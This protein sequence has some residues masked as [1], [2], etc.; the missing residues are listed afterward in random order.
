M[1]TL[2]FR[3]IQITSHKKLNNFYSEVFDPKNPKNKLLNNF[4]LEVSKTSLFYNNAFETFIVE[5][6]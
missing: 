1:V 2:N 3:F 5:R 4:K 6:K